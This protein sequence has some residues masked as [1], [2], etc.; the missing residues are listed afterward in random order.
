MRT[1]WKEL[2]DEINGCEKCRLCEKRTRVV[3]GEGNPNADL[4]LIG[5]FLNLTGKNPLTGP[6]ID[7]YGP[8]FPDMTYALDRDL[9]ALALATADKLHISLQ[10]GVYCWL[11]GPTYEPPA[12]IRMVRM[13]GA[14]AVG[15]STVPEVIVARHGGMRVLGISCITNMAAGILDQPLN[16]A[17]VTETANRVK[18]QF[19]NLLDRIIE[20]M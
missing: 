17:E 10:Q 3:P 8:R 14:D 6:N 20:K 19:R 15:M 9:K 2:I 18:G 1:S 13:L 16:H 11:N 7:E 5:D 12:E 4:M